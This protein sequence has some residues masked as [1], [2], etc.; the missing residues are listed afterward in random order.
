MGKN[1]AL[2]RKIAKKKAAAAAINLDNAK[3]HQMAALLAERAKLLTN[4]QKRLPKDKAA[5]LARQ[6]EGGRE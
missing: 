4:A 2:R 3:P 1:S 6:R 5:L